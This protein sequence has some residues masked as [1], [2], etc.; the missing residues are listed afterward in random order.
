MGKR[1]EGILSL[2]PFVSKRTLSQQKPQEALLNRDE[3][4]LLQ[5]QECQQLW[6]D[7]RCD[8]HKDEVAG[9]LQNLTSLREEK[10]YIDEMIDI[11]YPG[12]SIEGNQD[13]LF[14]LFQ[15]RHTASY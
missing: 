3:S 8:R 7:Q 13:Q 14:L 11:G 2:E 10:R 4:S 15:S 6:L 9:C 5:K 12:N 1:F